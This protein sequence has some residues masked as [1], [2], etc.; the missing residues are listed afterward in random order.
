MSR[1]ALWQSQE[2]RRPKAHVLNTWATVGRTVWE[3]LGGGP[4]L[5]QMTTRSML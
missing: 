5:E 3:E 4:L 1:K 2:Q